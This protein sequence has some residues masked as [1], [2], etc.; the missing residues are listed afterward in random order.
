MDGVLIIASRRE[1]AQRN[2]AHCPRCLT[3]QV[4]LKDWT[5]HPYKLQYK[6][7][8]CK[9]EFEVVDNY[10]RGYEDLL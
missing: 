1:N 6:C 5:T 10:M 8:V 9:N 4:Q 7:R 2:N 3:G